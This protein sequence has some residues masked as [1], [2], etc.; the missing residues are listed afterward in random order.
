MGKYIELHDAYLSIVE[1]LTH[2]GIA[3]KADVQ[4]L[5]VNAVELEETDDIGRILNRRGGRPHRTGRLSA[6]AV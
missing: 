1:S 4:I 6:S 2:A 5:W 3:N